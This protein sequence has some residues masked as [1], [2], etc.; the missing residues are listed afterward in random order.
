M[1]A[2]VATFA[3]FLACSDEDPVLPDPPDIPSLTFAPELGVDLSLMTLRNSGLYIRDL[4][5]GTGVRVGT[6]DGVAFNFAG[7]VH[8]GTFVDEGTYPTNMFSPGAIQG[9]DGE[10][11]YLIGSGQTIAAWDLGLDGMRIGGTRQ[12]VVPPKLAF[13][14]NGSLDGRVPPNAVLV[15]TLETLAAEP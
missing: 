1:T 13:G 3:V 10:F 6:D 12:L 4:V 7:F 14:A 5:E 9:I 2:T 8:D 11:Y 15:Y